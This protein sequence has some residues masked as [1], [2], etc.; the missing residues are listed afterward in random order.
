LRNDEVRGCGAQI[1]VGGIARADE[2]ACCL[3]GYGEGFL[4]GELC[5]G[6]SGFGFGVWFCGGFFGLFLFPLRSHRSRTQVGEFK[7]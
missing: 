4:E 1:A 2:Q 5:G 7:G 3:G 6:R